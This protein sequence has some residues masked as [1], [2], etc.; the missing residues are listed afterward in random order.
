[1]PRVGV[2]N[3][4]A[5]GRIAGFLASAAIEP[6][7]L[8]IEGEPGIGKTT[9]WLA[10]QEQARDAGFRVLSA[11]AAAAESVLAY[12]ALA[13]LLDGVPASA[14][15]DLPEPQRHAVDQVLTRADNGSAT[16]QRAVA[17]AFLSVVEHL[18]D[19]GPLLVAIDDLQW[20]DPSSTHVVAFAAR[21]LSGPVGILASV[22]T[23]TGSGAAGVWLQMPRPDAVNRIR[24]SPL[25]IHDLHAAVSTRLRRPFSRPAMGRIH[26]L[27]G[28]NPFYA[29]ELA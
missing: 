11:R 9:L 20:I 8:L 6:S 7:A 23:D 29:I 28:G 2:E 25:G 21:R 3:R 17:A 24:L 10:A 1:M 12:T 5:E 13:D 26:A 16:D 4:R 15:A 27:S 14:W 18:T 19:D 22:R